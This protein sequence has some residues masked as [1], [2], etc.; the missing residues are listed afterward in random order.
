MRGNAIGRC[1]NSFLFLYKL[2]MEFNSSLTGSFPRTRT[3]NYNGVIDL[4]YFNQ[5]FISCLHFVIDFTYNAII[6]LN[7]SHQTKFIRKYMSLWHQY[8]RQLFNFDTY[9][10]LVSV[11]RKRIERSACVNR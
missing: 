4:S 5:N 7:S 11:K 10:A 2:K 6:Q 1:R 3:I 9:C 8:N